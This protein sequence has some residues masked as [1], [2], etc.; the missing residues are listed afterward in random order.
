MKLRFSD[1]LLTVILAVVFL[2]MAAI[3]V[4]ESAFNASVSTWITRLLREPGVW[5]TAI[6][7]VL[8]ILCL[9]AVWRCL[10]VAFRRPKRGDMEFVEQKTDGAELRVSVKAIEG[11]VR[12]CVANHEEISLNSVRLENSRGGL[13]VIMECRTAADISIPLAVDALQKQLREYIM[14]STG[15]DIRQIQVQVDD[16]QAELSGGAYRLHDAV[17]DP[18]SHERPEGTGE[19]ER[20]GEQ[21]VAESVSQA[22][23]QEA[24]PTSEDFD[25]AEATPDPELA[26]TKVI[27]EMAAA[28][29]PALPTFPLPRQPDE[30]ADLTDDLPVSDQ[31]PGQLSEINSDQ[32]E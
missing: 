22:P 15:V 8:V 7:V 20:A 28:D 31:T 1:R 4:A 27:E 30:T 25:E 9:L 18:E 5:W 24:V 12:K 17:I 26:P 3:I 14:E 16:A 6:R 21:A 11:L 23:I 10:C 29:E 32:E 2:L 19:T 13:T